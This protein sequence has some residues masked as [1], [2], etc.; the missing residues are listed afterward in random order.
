LKAGAFVGNL[1]KD[2]N[3]KVTELEAR[4]IQI[5]SGTFKKHFETIR[6]V[7]LTA[8]GAKFPLPTGCR[9]NSTESYKLSPNAL[10]TLEVHTEA[11]RGPSVELV[12]QKALD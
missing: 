8:P 6:I 10:F 11:D 1:A 4:R 7:E 5:E 3:L 9:S 2:V 12:L